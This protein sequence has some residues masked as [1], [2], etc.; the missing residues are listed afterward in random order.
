MTQ[1]AFIFPGQGSQAIGMLAE[2]AAIY[3]IVQET[4]T[5]AS[6]I[7]GYDLWQ[8]AQ[9][10]PED[11]LNQ[12]DKTQPALLASG[13]AMWR[14]WQAQG[15]TYP[16]LMA[17]HS[18][19]EYT[20]LV[21]AESISYADGVELARDRGQFMQA[22]VNT[23]EGSMAAVLGLDDATIIAV[24]E[25][26]AQGEVVAAVNFN[27]PGQ[28]VIAG[29]QSAVERALKLAKSAGAKK[30]MPLRVSVPA[31][32]ALMAPAAENMAQRLAD[33]TINTPKVPVL[34]NL[35]VRSRT[36]AADIRYALVAQLYNPVRWVDTIKAI[37]AAGVTLL[38]TCG[39]GKVLSGLNK[40]IDPQIETLHLSDPAALD[41]AL[42]KA[43]ELAALALRAAG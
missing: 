43:A 3:P 1:H 14:I 38:F 21:C 10:G 39:P 18:F 22:A 34:H 32:C 42:H 12:T 15:G 29:H 31:H 20:A 28:V 7:L 26:A 6:D 25:Q 17:G 33:V 37:D 4:F 40:R 35:D 36:E 41:T 8:L 16:S 23:V 27:A 11:T 2:L 19:G 30:A 5:E 9:N 13:V 24:C